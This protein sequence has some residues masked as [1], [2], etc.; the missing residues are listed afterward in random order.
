[1]M[2]PHSD[3]LVF[4]GATGDLIDKKIFPALYAMERR[5]HLQM[6]SIAVAELGRPHGENC[7]P[8]TG[9]AVPP[10]PSGLSPCAAT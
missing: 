2:T 8:G 6:P 4:F 3:A 1:M 7:V 5:G 9:R 10:S